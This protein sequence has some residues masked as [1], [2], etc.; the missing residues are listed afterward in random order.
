[1]VGRSRLGGCGGWA[2]NA[3]VTVERQRRWHGSGVHRGRARCVDIYDNENEE[4]FCSAKQIMMLREY[5]DFYTYFL[6]VK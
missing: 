5:A 1:M 4:R 6:T 2:W 3:A